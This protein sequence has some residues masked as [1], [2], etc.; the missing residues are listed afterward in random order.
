MNTSSSITRQPTNTLIP[1]WLIEKIQRT[2]YALTDFMQIAL[3]DHDALK[4]VLAVTMPEMMEFRKQASPMATLMNMPFVALAPVLDDSRDWKSII[5]GPTPS[6]KV[7]Q[8]SAEMPLVDRVTARDIFHYNKD[9][10]QLL[11]DVLHMSLV[12][13]PLLGI[14]FELAAYLKSMPIGQLET[15]IS[16]IK[17]PLFRWRFNTKS[18]WDEYSSNGL[19]EESVAHYIM[20]TAPVRAG[21]LPY[22][23]IWT[24][25]R[26]DRA[27]KEFYARSMMQQGCRAS[28]ATNLFDLN[29]GKA[30]LIY[31]EYHGVK[32]PSGNNASSL[33]W[34]VD[35]GV[36]R[37]QATVYT[38][39]YRS[40]LA[41]DGNIPEALI[42][43]NDLMAKMFGK[44]S[45]ISPDRGNHLTRRMARDSLLRMAPCRSCGTHYILSNGEG[46]IELE[47]SFACPGCALLLTSKGQ[48]SKRKVKL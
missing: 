26:I 45:V 29:Q 9:Y 5:E 1:H 36:R 32:S 19:T 30:R 20:Q 24:S 33:T 31:K 21:D 18:F 12:A 35:Q 44:N 4:N 27:L 25:L 23:A 47:Q 3:A 40:A 13:V 10:L 8:L 7:N 41:S 43:S 38:W 48:S 2:N 15:A 11:K 28:T 17:F 37:L 6:A 16:P 22:Q 34:Y 42:A 46:K 14:S 39:L